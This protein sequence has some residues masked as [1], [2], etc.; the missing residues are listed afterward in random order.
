MN[1]IAELLELL[2]ERL[3]L[4]LE[5]EQCT[6][7]LNDCEIDDMG[8]YITKRTAIANQID[9]VVKKIYALSA[10]IDTEPPMEDIIKNRC[11]FRDV[12]EDL[13]PLFFV[14]Q[15]TIASIR[16]SSESNEAAIIRMRTLREML[17]K[18]ISE[19]K[20]TPRIKKY[21]SASGATN[22]MNDFSRVRK[23]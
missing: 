20:N 8:N 5:L 15:Q 14:S 22:Q 2:N 10:D 12:P 16:R 11:A 19:T 4:F 23:A 7:R 13:K 9:E 21:L 1:N 18:R 6:E 17:R 3:S